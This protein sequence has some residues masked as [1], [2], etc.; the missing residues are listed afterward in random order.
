MTKQWYVCNTGQSPEGPLT[1]QEIM[2]RIAMSELTAETRVAPMGTSIWTTLL[3]EPSFAAA[4]TTKGTVI[5]P[6][7]VATTVEGGS[8]AALPAP[9]SA[10]TV[11]PVVASAP[12]PAPPMAVSMPPSPL[13]P[14]KQRSSQR[15]GMAIAGLSLGVLLTAIVVAASVVHVSASTDMGVKAA[16]VRVSTSTGRGSGF[17]LRGP[18]EFAY[19][20]TAY[21]VVE[22][23][24]SILVQRDVETSDTSHYVE[25]YPETEIVAFDAEADLAVL[26]IKN[27]SASR[28]ATLP[29]AMAPLKDEKVASYG[30]PHSNLTNA[31]GLMSKDGKVLSLVRFPVDDRRYSR[32]VRDNAVD[33]I[34]ISSQLEPGFS[35]GPTCNERGEVVG[36]NTMKDNKHEGQNGAVSVVV[37]QKLL[38]QITPAAA[39]KDPTPEQAEVLLNRIASEYLSLP[40]QERWKVREVEFV[41]SGDLPALRRFTSFFRQAERGTNTG[42]DKEHKLSSAA[43]LGVRFAKLPGKSLDTYFSSVTTDALS[44]CEQTNVRL[45]TW[46]GALSG[47]AVSVDP[48]DVAESC[49]QYAYRPFAWDLTAATLAWDEQEQTQYSVTKIEPVDQDGGI[50]KAAVRAK[51]RGTSFDVL[52]ATD[53][54]R[55]RLKVFDRDGRPYALNA[56][57]SVA[58]ADIAGEWLA[59]EQPFRIS[60]KD[61]VDVDPDEH[62]YITIHDDQTASI[63]HVVHHR[64]TFTEGTSNL[65]SCTRQPHIDTSLVQWFLGKVE[66]GI[67]VAYPE[68]A[69]ERTG[70]TQCPIQYSHDRAV[71]LKVSGPALTM[72]RTNGEQY[73]EKK[74]FQRR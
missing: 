16:V 9:A 32:V 70:H 43:W 42:F 29:L 44:K 73:P 6:P 12:P 47:E 25:A 72:Y 49:E 28:F 37:L 63:K 36:I 4:F 55:L 68:R 8:R 60:S 66:G 46:L 48:N 74:V 69:P 11:L 40:V 27:L 14:T 58:T 65:F 50:Y 33:A 3:E 22:D 61:P 15:R 18:D 67:V 35:G 39:R 38:Q 2:N 71:A 64:Y 13:A 20:A 21:H 59:D 62:L 34:L 26:R 1:T 53:D 54:G 23:G 30:F 24:G 7:S 31:A 52:L 45:Q 5:T 56:P 57:R 41:S 10:P 19:V 17:L 51:G